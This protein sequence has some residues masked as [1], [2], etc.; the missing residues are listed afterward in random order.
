MQS[1]TIRTPCGWSDGPLEVKACFLECRNRFD[2]Q[3][4]NGKIKQ[5]DQL[6]PTYGFSTN[7]SKSFSSTT[8]A[9]KITKKTN[10]YQKKHRHKI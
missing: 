1:L 9:K 5:E 3:Q 6:L 8:P 4:R 10:L 7:V 2:I